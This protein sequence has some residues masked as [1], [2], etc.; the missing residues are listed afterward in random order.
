MIILSPIFLL[1]DSFGFLTLDNVGKEL[2][3]H[4]AQ[5]PGR[6]QFS[7]FHSVWLYISYQLDALIIIYS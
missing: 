6:A 7:F 1:R 2:S 4:A 5:Q 3:L